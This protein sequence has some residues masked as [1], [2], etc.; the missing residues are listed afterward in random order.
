MHTAQNLPAH[1][2]Q[3]AKTIEKKIMKHNQCT[4]HDNQ[5]RIST[6]LKSLVMGL[7]KGHLGSLTIHVSERGIVLGGN[8]NSFHA[9]QL[10]QEIVAKSSSLRILSNDLVVNE[11][12]F[13]IASSEQF[14]PN[15]DESRTVHDQ[16]KA[17]VAQV[18]F[19]TI[20]HPSDFTSASHVAFVHALKIALECQ[21]MLQMMHVDTSYQADWDDFPSVLETLIR[22]KVL[23]EGSEKN[24]VAKLDLSVSK[25]IASSKDPV[26]ACTDYFEINAVDL[27]VLSVHQRD[28]MMRW[29][30]NIVGERISQGSKQ[31]T[32]FIPVG[33]SGF[34]SQLDGS[35]T[36]DHIL[37][38]VV[39]KPRSESAVLFVQNLISSLNLTSGTV[40]LL[41]VGPMETM[42]FVQHPQN[43][44]WTWNRVRLEGDR[45][46]TIVNFAEEIGAKLIVMTTDGPDRFLDGLRGT[47]S[48][49][50]LRKSHCPVA[51]I[52]IESI[53]E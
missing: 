32:L 37:V 19:D 7:L 39:K 43:V 18:R 23:P 6:E 30:G 29:L 1:P 21:A 36:L 34:V 25:L 4:E 28:G 20:F 50:V 33:Q 3:L 15:F 22:W 53:V 49:R 42:P 17:M 12:P 45:T 47:T 13:D 40:T 41:H 46:D 27:I 5:E 14:V 48:E 9:K 35:V 16:D 10:V 52:P 38:P 24:A 2:W 8:C 31:N 51:V 26:K 44:G 11:H